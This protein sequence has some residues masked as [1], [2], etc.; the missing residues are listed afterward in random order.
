MENI[1]PNIEGK[2]PKIDKN[3]FVD[4]SAVIIG[5]VIIEKDVYVGPNAVIR[6]DEPPTKNILIKEGAN[7]QDLVVIHCLRNAPIVVGRETSIAHSSVIHGPAK[8]GD[9]AFIGFN[10]VIF[11]AEIGNNAVVGHNSVI[12]G[13]GGNLKIPDNKWIPP[14]TSIYKDSDGVIR[15]FLPDGTVLTD[16]NNLPD[17]PEWY[18]EVPGEVVKVNKELNLGYK[19]FIK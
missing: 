8:I 14:N 17:I 7:I 1:L 11:G 5:D 3:V 9:N 10:S 4:K 19:K 13:V 6:C 15:A 16:F 12:D 18:R 2:T